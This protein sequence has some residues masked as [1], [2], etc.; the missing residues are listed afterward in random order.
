[1]R[2]LLTYGP[3][4]PRYLA[5]WI[6]AAPLLAAALVVLRARPR[7]A[8]AI[9]LSTLPTFLLHNPPAW[10]PFPLRW[11]I[12]TGILVALGLWLAGRLRGD[13]PPDAAA[14]P[15]R[16]PLVLGL[17]ALALAVRAPL[18][19]LD[20]GIADIPRASETAARQLLD[21]RNPWTQPNPET[22]A[23]TY[24]YPAGSLL[25]HLPFVALAPREL[26]GEAWAGARLTV[27]AGEVAAVVALALAGAAAGH[28]RGG[29]IAAAAYALSP[30]LIRDSGM[31]VANDLLLGL[32]ALGAAVALA[33]GRVAL[34]AVLAGVAVSVKPAAVVLLPLL[35]AAAGPRAALLAA[36][37]PV[38]LQMPFLLWPAPGLHGIAAI[39]EP[40]GRSEPGAVLEYSTWAPVYRLVGTGEAALRAVGSLGAGIGLAGGWWAGR[41]LRAAPAPA[42]TAR[43]AAAFSFALLVPFLFAFVQRTNYQDWYLAP[44]LLCAGLVGAAS[45]QPGRV[46]RR[47]V[48][49]ESIGFRVDE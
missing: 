4:I 32:A 42:S 36:A 38:L 31:T 46:R 34:S 47:T 12:L 43:T 10:L 22:V 14:R 20:P 17:A 23:G 48:A 11:L 40:V 45:P 27:L 25:A 9:G 6:A 39:L 49:R 7:A 28:P 13:A 3:G 8:L 5:L 1:V 41:K 21:G 19:W 30:T 2:A 33:R 29:V 15:A 24:Q 26:A 35:L 44:F 16:W 18:A 37:V